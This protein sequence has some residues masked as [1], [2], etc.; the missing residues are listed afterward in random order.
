MVEEKFIDEK[1]P[2]EEGNIGYFSDLKTGLLT[3]CESKIA[4]L[5]INEE[6]T[7]YPSY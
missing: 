6:K 1:P 5:S 4:I 2:M 3:I 7:N